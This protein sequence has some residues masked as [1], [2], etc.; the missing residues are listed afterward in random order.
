MCPGD[1][2]CAG[3][4][5]VSCW[6]FSIIQLQGGWGVKTATSTAA[7]GW[8]EKCHLL[9]LECLPLYCS[10]SSRPCNSMHSDHVSA[11]KAVVVLHSM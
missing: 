5:G 10:P 6:R 8:C 11:R 1:Q 7:G 2:G 3:E 4:Q 9:L